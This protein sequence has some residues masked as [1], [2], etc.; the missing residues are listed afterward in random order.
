M[1]TDNLATR[2]G[3]YTKAKGSFR[4]KQAQ[5]A[6]AKIEAAS[7]VKYS[8]ES[9][10]Q[11][12][13]HRQFG[14]LIKPI[15][16]QGNQLMVLP[17]IL[18][19]C[20]VFYNTI[21][22]V[23]KNYVGSYSKCL[24]LGCATGRLTAEL[25]KMASKSDCTGLD[26]SQCM[27]NYADAIVKGEIGTYF[28]FEAPESR[29]TASSFEIPCFGVRNCNF[30]KANAMELPFRNAEFDFIACINLMHRVPNPKLVISEIAR[31]LKP[32]GVLLVSN[33]Y[34][35]EE[36]YTPQEFWFDNFTEQLDAKQ[37]KLQFEL[38]GIPWISNTF[39]RKYTTAFNHI[40]VFRKTE[41]PYML[42]ANF[43]K[44]FNVF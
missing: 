36:R 7:D 26:A 33:T 43:F 8:D 5:T 1:K 19:G 27:I 3:S 37:W 23:A 40:Q 14:K 30:V 17:Q 18:S 44:N 9:F 38:D 39:N 2:L 21:V 22:E 34:D 20:E 11:K 32:N 24:D 25:A 31:C 10:V 13:L 41:K 29:I 42:N 28:K 12:F 35:W 6:C 4:I 16:E 15:G